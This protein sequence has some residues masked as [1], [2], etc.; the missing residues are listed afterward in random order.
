[1]KKN[2]KPSVNHRLANQGGTYSLILSAVVLAILI[3]LNIFVSKLPGTATKLDMSAAKL[4]SITS[5]TKAVINNLKQDVTI[6]WVTQAGQE[7]QIIENLLDKYDYLS[8]YITVEKKN[9]DVYPTFTQQY[10]D[11]TVPNNSLIVESGTKSRYVSYNDIY[12]QEAAI[13]QEN[14][15][16]DGEG[17]ISSAIDYVVSEKLPLLYVVEGHG[18]TPLTEDFLSALDKENIET[19]TLSLITETRVPA[20]ADCVMIHGPS[21]DISPEE[22]QML[23]DYTGNGG[24]LLVM[25]GP[26]QNGTLENLYSVLEEYGILA[27]NGVIVEEDRNNYGFGYPYILMPNIEDSALTTPLKEA[28]YHVILPIAQGLAVKDSVKEIVTPLLTTSE[29][30]FSKAAGFAMSTHEKEDGD[31]DGPFPVAITT[32]TGYEGE[33]IWF[34][35]STMLDNTYNSYSAGANSDLI[36]NSLSS[37]MGERDA[38]SIRSKS[39]NYN[40]LTISQSTANTIKALMIGVFPVA[41]LGVGIAVVLLRKKAQK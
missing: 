12:Q 18:E 7:N 35:C 34:S 8:D 4:Y 38:I 10:T 27:V 16:F 24:K 11:E 32:P 1:M 36:L 6:Y 17:A 29:S 2:T 40:Y 14:H 25:A 31:T 22:A 21:S 15:I 9:P 28:R 5:N 33:L 19:A 30:S 23:I 26:T 3:V 37:L 13:N 41:Y 20:D 39:L